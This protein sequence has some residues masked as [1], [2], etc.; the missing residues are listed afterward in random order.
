M[1]SVRFVALAAASLTTA[2]GV[3]AQPIGEQPACPPHMDQAMIDAGLLNLSQLQHQGQLIFD[4]RFNFLDGRGRPFSTGGGAPRAIPGPDFIRTSAPDS[5]SCAGCHNQPRSGGAGDFVAN[6]FVLAQT[7]DPVTQ[8]VSPQFSDERNTLGMMGAGPIEMLAREM[9]AELQATREQARALAAASNHN[10]TRALRAK[11]VDFGTITVRPDGKID[12]IGI[13]GVDWDLVVK[14]FHQKGAAVSIREFNNNALNHH[15][16]MQTTERFGV[17]TDPDGDGVMNEISPGDVTALTLFQAALNT[18]QQVLPKGREARQACDR[19]E[20][21][22]AQIGCASCHVPEFTLESHYFTEPNPYNPAGNLT[23]AGVGRVFSFDMTREGEKPRLQKRGR[24]QAIIRP[25]TDLKRHNL[26]DDEI[27]HF[28]N[29]LVPQG[30]INGNEPAS[31]FTIAPFPRPT[32]DFL[33]R[34]LWDCGNTAPYGHRGDLSTITEAIIEH[35]GEGRQTREAFLA[36]SSYDQ[37]CIVEFLKSL[38]V[39]PP[40]DSGRDADDEHGHHG[41]R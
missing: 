36:M 18:P 32:E 6:V 24:S 8:S 41:G 16:G 30:M 19:G 39:V 33:S 29:E 15:H 1:I 37:A 11:G 25:F 20:R 2:S 9:T 38:Q 14:P 5:T 7:L 23:P 12:P 13:Q 22:F 21:L 4:A 26:N 34:K 31:D 17:N 40:G 10:V 3:L 27:N 35:G 28:A